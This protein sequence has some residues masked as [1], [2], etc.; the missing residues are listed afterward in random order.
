MVRCR[1]PRQGWGT[2]R[3][4]RSPPGYGPGGLFSPPPARGRPGVG[5]GPG[6]RQMKTQVQEGVGLGRAA[7]ETVHDAAKDLAP[8][9]PEDDGSRGGLPGVNHHD[10]LNGRRRNLIAGR[11]HSCWTASGSG[12]R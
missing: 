5:E 9:F 6:K 2:D 8:V 4:S 11:N 7:V 3:D 1:L 10:L 12:R